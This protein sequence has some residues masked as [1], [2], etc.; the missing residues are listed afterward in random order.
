[1]KKIDL[2]KLIKDAFGKKANND[3][4]GSCSCCGM[5][6]EELIKSYDKK[7]GSKKK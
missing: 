7:Q 6:S 4:G 5:T 3:C 1:M 2:K